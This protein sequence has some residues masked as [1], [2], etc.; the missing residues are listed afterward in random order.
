MPSDPG[1]RV[2]ALVIA[3]KER[4]TGAPADPMEVI[5]EHGTVKLPNAER[6]YIDPRKIRDYLLSST[7]PAGRP[8]ARFFASLGYARS[9][10]ARL[11]KDLLDLAAR[12]RGRGPVR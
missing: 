3:T 6:A 4:A 5:R 8:K 9:G 7:H 2:D 12:R 1:G 10:W 11:R